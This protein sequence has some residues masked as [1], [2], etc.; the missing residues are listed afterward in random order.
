[1]ASSLVPRSTRANYIK[2]VCTGK[3][4]NEAKI[5]HDFRIVLPEK[6]ITPKYV[7]WPCCAVTD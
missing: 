6:L 5:G 4:G 3:P 1:M 7:L 2:I